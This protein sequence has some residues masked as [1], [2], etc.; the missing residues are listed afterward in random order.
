MSCKTEN[1]PSTVN[2]QNPMVHYILVL[3]IHCITRLSP[4]YNT[5]MEVNADS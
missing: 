5:G 4:R 2:E 1:Q 3:D